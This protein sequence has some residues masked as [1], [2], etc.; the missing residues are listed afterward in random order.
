M[1]KE[2]IYALERPV[3]EQFTALAEHIFLSFKRKRV[4]FA[5]VGISFERPAFTLSV[6]TITRRRRCSGITPFLSNETLYNHTKKSIDELFPIMENPRY[7]PSRKKT[8]WG[9]EPFLIEIQ[10]DQTFSHQYKKDLHDRF[11]PFT[12][13][14]EAVKVQQESI[15]LIDIGQ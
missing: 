8:I 14:E 6:E 15:C 5:W 12:R 2:E 4:I 13:L 11:G 7:W 10:P 9:D 3:K 1:K